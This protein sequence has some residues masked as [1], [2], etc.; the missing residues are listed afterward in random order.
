M[1]GMAHQ[2]GIADTGL[3]MSTPGT[4]GTDLVVRFLK[5]AEY[6]GVRTRTGLG[7]GCVDSGGVDR[8]EMG[9]RS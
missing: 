3:G 4:E 5:T 6:R 7:G 8:Q 9:G 2:A 1:E